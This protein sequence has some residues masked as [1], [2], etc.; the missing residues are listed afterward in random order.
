VQD[1]FL[2]GPHPHPWL[3]LNYGVRYEHATPPVAADNPFANFDP[4]DDHARAHRP[5]RAEVLFLNESD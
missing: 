4:H 5:V 1:A 2:H 3:A